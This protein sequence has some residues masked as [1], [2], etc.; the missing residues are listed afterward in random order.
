[1]KKLLFLFVIL[2]VFF[3]CKGQ[4]TGHKTLFDNGQVKETYYLDKN[5]Q[6]TGEANIYFD[7]GKLSTIST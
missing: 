7:N 4:S 1:M 3:S 2:H 6:L 5:G